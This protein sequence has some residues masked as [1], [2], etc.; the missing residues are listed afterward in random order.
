M[1]MAFHPHWSA[2]LAPASVSS[3][4]LGAPDRRNGDEPDRRVTM[5][6]RAPAADATVVAPREFPRGD[7]IQ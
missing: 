3:S 6:L 2:P 1:L 4:V 7:E 5:V